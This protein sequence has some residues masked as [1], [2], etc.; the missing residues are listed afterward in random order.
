MSD[1]IKAKKQKRKL[2][3]HEKNTK[4]PTENTTTKF[5]SITVH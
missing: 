5:E 4:Q 1:I 2:N 3:N